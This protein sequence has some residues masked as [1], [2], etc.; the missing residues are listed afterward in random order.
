MPDFER[1]IDQLRVDLAT[2]PEEKAHALGFIAGKRHARKQIAQIAAFVLAL[3][4]LIAVLA[5]AK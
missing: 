5:A 2:N 3:A 1:I 4:V